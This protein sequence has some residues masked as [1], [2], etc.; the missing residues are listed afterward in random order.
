MIRGLLF[1]FSFIAL[2][3]FPSLSGCAKPS[4][5]FLWKASGPADDRMLR[6]TAVAADPDGN[7][8][9]ADRSG[10]FFIFDPSGR[11]LENWGAEGAGPGQ[12]LF[13]WGGAGTDDGLFRYTAGIVL[14][15]DSTVVVA[16]T[17]GDR[18]QKFRLKGLP[19]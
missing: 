9:A 3:A 5:Q 7:I 19:R 13:S 11:F 15:E 1:S 10:R 18:I 4:A 6:A 16:D 14:T 8:W 17:N 12:S 2:I